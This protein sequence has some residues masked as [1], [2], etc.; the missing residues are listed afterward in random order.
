[1]RVHCTVLKAPKETHNPHNRCVIE[2]NVKANCN[3]C[4]CQ[5]DAYVN[6]HRKSTAEFINEEANEEA[7][8]DFPKAEADHGKD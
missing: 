2:D 4:H 5:N 3:T 7:A 1:M 8:K 6:D